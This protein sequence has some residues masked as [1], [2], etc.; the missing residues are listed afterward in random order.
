MSTPP[1]TSPDADDEVLVLG[2]GVV[3]LACAQALAEAGQPARVLERDRIGAATSRGNCG[4]LTPSHALPLA[5]PGMVGTALRWMLSPEAPFL[6]RPRWDP[7][8]WRWMLRFAAR[9]DAAT[10]ARAIAPKAA[11]LTASMDLLDALVR[12]RGLDCGYRRDGLTYVYRDEQAF[13]AAVAEHMR[14]GAHGIDVQVWDGDTA[15][16]DEPCLRPGVAGALHF[17]GDGHLRPERYT[18]ELARLL[19]EDGGAVE[20]G[21]EVASLRREGAAWRVTATDGRTWS[22]RRLLLAAGPWAPR[23]LAPLGLRLPVVPGKGYSITFGRP[24]RVPKRPLVLKERSVCVTAWEDGFRLGSTMEFAGYDARLTRTR[25]DALERGAREGLV[26]PVGPGQR[27]EWFGWRPMTWDDLPV[28]GEAP[29][30]P[31]LW[32]AV[33]HGMMGIGMSAVTG[34]LVADLMLGRE[35]VVDPAPYRFARFAG[36]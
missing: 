28:L 5:A 16:A 29:S 22:A 27:E 2:G 19:G 4:T 10:Y 21:V 34:H 30:H 14:L 13:K 25:L 31:G 26:E 6:V 3:G 1:R 12:R 15:L 11:L 33:G 24:G 35:P 20:E 32:L 36:G 18:A 8:L 23:L 9:C 17:P 7:D